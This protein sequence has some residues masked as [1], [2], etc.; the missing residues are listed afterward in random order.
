M[1]INSHKLL[2]H[3]QELNKKIDEQQ[4]QIEK[5]KTKSDD[6]D[7]IFHEKIQRNI[8]TVSIEFEKKH[9]K[10]GEDIH[11]LRMLFKDYDKKTD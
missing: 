6:F 8:N 1:T 5:I 7:L 10:H 9:K 4:L 3:I 2:A 11:L